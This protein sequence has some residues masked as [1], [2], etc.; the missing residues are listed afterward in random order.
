MG[1]HNP[2]AHF[3]GNDD[4]QH[5]E[6]HERERLEHGTR[7]IRQILKWRKDRAVTR[8]DTAVLPNALRHD[9]GRSG[10]GIHGPLRRGAAYIA[11]VCERIF[12][13]RTTKVSVPRGRA[14]PTFHV[15]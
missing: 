4:R 6:Q 9:T 8:G 12:P 2:A 5:R 14:L 11:K 7:E 13:S 15:M 10:F 3:H 1:V